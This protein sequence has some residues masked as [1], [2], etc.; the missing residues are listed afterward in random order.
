MRNTNMNG[1]KI[2]DIKV[3]MTESYS[4]TITDTDVK[5]FSGV[6]GD[7]NPVHMDDV[8]AEK[9]RY[10]RRIAHGLLSSSFFSA[11]FG[12]KLPG[13]GC[14]YVEQNLQFKRPVYI[15]DTVTARIT[16]TRVDLFKRRIFFDTTCIVKNKKVIT[17]CAELYMPEV[18]VND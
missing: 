13:E 5:Q 16:V 14:V 3:G 8:Y 9:S 15:D 10:K 11:L 18:K 1:Y 2:E 6:S 4:Q 7:K 12:T 17:G